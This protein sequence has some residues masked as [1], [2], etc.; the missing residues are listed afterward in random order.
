MDQLT[1]LC[2]CCSNKAFK[3]CCAPYLSGTANAKTVKQLMRSRYCAF[4]LGGYADYLIHTWHPSTAPDIS[5]L[6]ET[7]PEWV[8]L[9]VV[10]SEQNGN[11]GTVEFKAVYIDEEGHEAVHH[12]VSEFVRVKGKW[13]Y[14]GQQL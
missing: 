7:G 2:P 3:H 6:S 8:M 14:V 5:D 1:L 11:S 10:G 4:A 12:E 13:Y 9:D